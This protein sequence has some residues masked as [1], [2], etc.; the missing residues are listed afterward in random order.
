[1]IRTK[2][3]LSVDMAASQAAEIDY[4]HLAERVY[5]PVVRAFAPAKTIKS[6]ATKSFAGEPLPPSVQLLTTEPQRD[7][8]LFVR[9]AHR[10]G[11]NEAAGAHAAPPPSLNL[12]DTY[13]CVSVEL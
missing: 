4:R 9:L 6:M 7:G 13:R 10:F 2:H 8:S 12:G 1:M 5:A 3:W 11:A